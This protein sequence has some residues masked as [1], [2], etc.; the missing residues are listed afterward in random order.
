MEL[1]CCKYPDP[2]ELM[3]EWKHN[4]PALY[5]YVEAT[6]MGI[7]GLVTDK[8][9]GKGIPAANI[10]VKEINHNIYTTNRGEYWRLLVPG[11]Y[12]VYASIWRYRKDFSNYFKVLVVGFYQDLGIFF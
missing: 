11:K 3:T 10:V 12:H 6:H 4:E 2:S 8:D 9:T 5:K 7:K 1:S